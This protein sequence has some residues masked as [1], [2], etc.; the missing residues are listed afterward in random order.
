MFRVLL[1]SL[2]PTLSLATT[3]K[4]ALDT[5]SATCSGAFSLDSLSVVCGDDDDGAC[6]PG[7]EVSISGQSTSCW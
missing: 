7:E 6:T 4:W 2:I 5:S 3:T 1:L